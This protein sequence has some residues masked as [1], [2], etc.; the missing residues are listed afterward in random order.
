MKKNIIAFGICLFLFLAISS[1]YAQN[2]KFTHQDTLRGSITPEREWWDLKYYHLNVKVNPADSSLA[3][4]NIVQYKVLKSSRKMQID[5]QPPMQILKIQ[6]DGKDL[7]YTRD[8]NAFFVQLEKRQKP[9]S[10][11]KVIVDF[12]GKPKVSK[13]PPWSGGL[14]WKK[15]SNNNHYIATTCQGDGASLWW[16]CKDHQYDE[17][18]SMLISVTVPNN[19]TDVSNGRLR[20][21][22]DNP[23]MTKTFNWFVSNPINNYCVNLNIGNYIHFSEKY[24]G[25]KGILDCDYYVLPEN[26][27]KAKIQFKDVKRMLDAFEHWFGPY[28]FYKDSYK[29]VDVSYTGMEHQSSVTY[30]NGYKNGYRGRDESRT[31]WGMKFDFIIIHESAHEWFGN[32]I[33]SKDIADM[34]IHESFGAY[35][36]SLFTDFHFGSQAGNEYLIG[37]RRNIRNERPIISSYNVNNDPPGDQYAKGANMLHTLRQIVN[38]DEKFRNII[39]GISKTFYHQTVTT[40]QIEKYFSKALGIDLTPFFNQYLRTAKIPVFEYSIEG[41][42]LKYKWNNI[43]PGFAMD[44]RIKINESDRSVSP[45]TD[46]SEIDVP[47]DAKIKVD[48]NYYVFSKNM[49]EVN[50]AK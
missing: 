49:N 11:N 3:G 43:V 1:I 12:A 40:G 31:G 19:L 41:G 28:P 16:P 14:S 37:T 33:T 25:E 23:D 17:P 46:W 20:S 39:R 36:E 7:K 8:G 22:K 42:K 4:Q 38:N 47:A 26:L 32:S 48:P 6:Q 44:V 50:D 24:K 5:L 15:D 27:E 9:G 35:S 13:N 30:G 2:Q 21:V 34:W 45:M 18:D 29:L 10:I